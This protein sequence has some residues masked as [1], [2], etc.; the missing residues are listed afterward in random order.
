[1]LLDKQCRYCKKFG[2]N[3]RK[4]ECLSHSNI[5][6]YCYTCLFRCNTC[7][8]LVCD[9]CINDLEHCLECF[10]EIQKIDNAYLNPYIEDSECHTCKTTVTDKQY[11]VIISANNHKINICNNCHRMLKVKRINNPR[12]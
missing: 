6:M 2:P 11:Y 4:C 10:N 8:K 7:K 3:L 5:N 12:K 1:M 9:G